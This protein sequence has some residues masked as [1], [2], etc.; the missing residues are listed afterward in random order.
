MP[1]TG[2]ADTFRYCD[3]EVSMKCGYSRRRRNLSE[4]SNEVDSSDDEGD[5]RPHGLRST[6]DI[7]H[8]SRSEEHTSEL[9]S[10]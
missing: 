10:R 3:R 7:R 2:K 5:R 8:D 9:Q 4:D 1:K 6:R